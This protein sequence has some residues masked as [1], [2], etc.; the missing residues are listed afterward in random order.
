MNFYLPP[1]KNIVITINK[2]SKWHES[3]WLWEADGPILHTKIQWE[4][5]QSLK[6]CVCNVS[7][8]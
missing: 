1:L 6:N 5:N 7:V 3:A 2:G 4:K 8:L